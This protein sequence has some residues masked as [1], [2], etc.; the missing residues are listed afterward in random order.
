MEDYGWMFELME[1]SRKNF[2]EAR[3]TMPGPKY[4]R[5]DVVAFEFREGEIIEGMIEI[6]DRFGTFEQ[7]EEPSY[8]VY[9]FENNTLYKHV[10]ES[11]VRDFIRKGNP[12]EIHENARKMLEEEERS[13]KAAETDGKEERP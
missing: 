12:E 3:K 2:E 5:G 13:R 7:N 10:R 6:V 8:D 9:R 4:D 11:L 1:E